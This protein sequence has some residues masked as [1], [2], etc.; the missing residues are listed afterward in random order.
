MAEGNIT[1]PADEFWTGCT[2]FCTADCQADHRGE[3]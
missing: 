1:D 3:E 2:D